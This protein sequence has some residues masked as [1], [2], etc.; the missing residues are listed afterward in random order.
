MPVALWYGGRPK[1][2]L[3]PP[4]V[5]PVV[6]NPGTLNVSFQTYSVKGWVEAVWTMFPT[7]VPPTAR[8]KGSLAGNVT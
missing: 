5:A 4:P 3:I 8:T 1:V 7:L 6:V 2:S